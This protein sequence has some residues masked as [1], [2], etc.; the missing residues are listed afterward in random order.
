MPSGCGMWDLG[1]GV[2]DDENQISRRSE[3]RGYEVK[4]YEEDA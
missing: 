4:D 1:Y 2:W 3:L